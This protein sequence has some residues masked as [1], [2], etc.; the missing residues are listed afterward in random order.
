MEEPVVTENAGIYVLRW[1]SKALSI[2][3]DRLKNRHD[4]LSG[5]IS[6]LSE[7]PASP[8]LLHQ[9]RL[10]LSST[11]ARDKLIKVLHGRWDIPDWDQIIELTCL[12]ILQH[13]RC[14]HPIVRYADMQTREHDLYF[15]QPFLLNRQANLLYGEGG[16][17]KSFFATYL[18]VLA[19]FGFTDPRTQ[20]STMGGNVLYL[21][22][23]TDEA[24]VS[25]RIAGIVMGLD[26][27]RTDAGLYY[28]SC[29]LRL[30]D[31]I[32]AIQR[33]CVEQQ[34]QLVIVD[35]VGLACGDVLEPAP[36]I[37]YFRAL[38]TL[39]VTTLSIDHVRKNPDSGKSSAFGS[40]YK[41]NLARSIWE[42]RSLPGQEQ[43]ELTLGFYHRKVNHGSL[44]HARGF[45]VSLQEGF[46]KFFPQDLAEVEELA[47]G[48]DLKY[49]LYKCLVSRTLSKQ[50]LHDILNPDND[51]HG[52]KLDSIRK[53]LERNTKMFNKIG[54]Q[55]GLVAHAT[56]DLEV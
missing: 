13:V 52:V 17:G 28:R 49:R 38:R 31:D 44:H 3:V 41:M 7:Q 4:A 27:E 43:D 54:E 30:V 39:H 22:W 40:V 14:G 21:D 55:W 6:V 15:C 11:A 5:E 33:I 23:E 53:T 42:I 35:S 26:S 48:V 10:N 1:P 9:A 16:S 12:R 50:E 24:E 36:V 8:G 37:E 20:L 51:P 32:E 47:S 34:I 45:K 29:D 25:E 18:S 46:T 2:R 19:S 56:N